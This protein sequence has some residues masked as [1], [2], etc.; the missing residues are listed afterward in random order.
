MSE[1]LVPAVVLALS[2][3]LTYWF[4]IRPMVRGQH[5]GLVRS[6]RAT[7]LPAVRPDEVERLRDEVVELRS[8]LLEHRR[9]AI[10]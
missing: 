9:G 6:G 8:Q 5:C 1:L 2:S 3:A 10:D 4:C 7:G